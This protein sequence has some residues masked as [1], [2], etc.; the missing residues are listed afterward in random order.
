MSEKLGPVFLG[1]EHEVF[2]GKSF[3]QQNSGFSENINEAI[4]AEVHDLIEGAY[5]RA[6]DILNEHRGQL[7]D[8]AQLLIER[9]KLD[10]EEFAAFMNGQSLPEAKPEPEASIAEEEEPSDEIESYSGAEP[11][12]ESEV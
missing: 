10:E 6:E 9:E 4:D 12:I 3:S 2:L 7:D 5:K 8:L 11:A 1:S